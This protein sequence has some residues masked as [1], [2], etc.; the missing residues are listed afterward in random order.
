MGTGN[1][2]YENASKVFVVLEHSTDTKYECNLCSHT[3]Y[4]SYYEEGSVPDCCP[5][6]GAEEHTEEELSN[7]PE[8]YDVED[9]LE[10]V[11][12]LAETKFGTRCVKEVVPDHERNFPGKTIFHVSEEKLLASVDLEVV[13]TAWVRSGYYEAAC[14]DWTLEVRAGGRYVDEVPEVTE[15]VENYRYDSEYPNLAVPHGIAAHTWLEATKE[16]LIKEVEALFEEV[17]TPYKRV[18]TFS[19]GETIYEKET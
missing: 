15:I 3:W 17:S 19:N 11:G 18:A 16:R 10:Y 1:F 9:F 6:C 5:S 14:L 8:A 12:D 13:V 7:A 2:Y 4:A